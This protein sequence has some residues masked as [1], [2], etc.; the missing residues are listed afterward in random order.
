M[1]EHKNHFHVK[2]SHFSF[3]SRNVDAKERAGKKGKQ[4]SL[5]TIF[6]MCKPFYATSPH[7]TL[8]HVLALRSLFFSSHVC[9]K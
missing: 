8:Y 3:Q 5:S 2:P 7:S 4:Q 6:F 1:R 9:G